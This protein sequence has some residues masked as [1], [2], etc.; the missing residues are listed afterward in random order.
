MTALDTNVLVRLILLDDPTQVS[1][2]RALVA[3]GP[4]FVADTV[5]LESAWVLRTQG[6][7]TDRQVAAELRHVLDL[8]TVTVS[9][10]AA[11]RAA[12]DDVDAGMGVA[13]AFH[14]A[15][16]ASATRLATFDRRFA[17]AAAGRP[18]LAIDLL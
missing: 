5:L 9:D 12:L 8:P 3:S 16:S 11:I 4:C 18:G 7:L 13:D 14:R 10:E 6:A 15:L 1:R 17:E 2:S